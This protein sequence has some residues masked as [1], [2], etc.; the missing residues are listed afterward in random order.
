[1]RHYTVSDNNIGSL[2]EKE[3]EIKYLTKFLK[4]NSIDENGYQKVPCDENDVDAVK[5]VNI[6]GLNFTIKTKKEGKVRNLFKEFMEKGKIRE[7]D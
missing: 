2:K 3:A 7:K 6:F 4:N 5:T 1:M